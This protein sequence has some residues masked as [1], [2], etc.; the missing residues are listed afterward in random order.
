MT[1]KTIQLAGVSAL[2]L[3]SVAAMAFQW[4]AWRTMSGSGHLSMRSGPAPSNGCAFA[5]RN[6]TTNMTLLGAKIRYIHSGRVDNDILPE[7]GPQKSLGGWTAF[8]VE[9]QCQNVEVQVYDEQ[10]R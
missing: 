7:L 6:D 10:W 2:A 8:S 1:K 4:S 9:D 5:F 3:T